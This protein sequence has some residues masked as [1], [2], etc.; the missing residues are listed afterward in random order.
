MFGNPAEYDPTGYLER[1]LGANAFKTF[2]RGYVDAALSLYGMPG[3][4][5]PVQRTLRVTLDENIQLIGYDLDRTELIP[6]QILQ[7]TLHWQATAPISKRYTVFAHIIGGM[8][9]ATQS[10]VWAQLDNEPAGGSRPTTTWQI[11]A[12][13]DDRYGLMLPPDA[14]PGEYALEVGMYDPA[15]LERLPVHDSTGARIQEDR[16]LLNSINVK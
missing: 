3:T 15:T 14:P 13:I 11:G 2:S 12:T 9:P 7:L 5:T 4:A 6:G 16:V 8:N 1:W 10:P